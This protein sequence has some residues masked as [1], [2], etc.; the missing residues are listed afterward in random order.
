MSHSILV[1]TLGWLFTVLIRSYVQFDMYEIHEYLPKKK[2]LKGV[3][4]WRTS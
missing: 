4:C 1:Q 3:H 2:T